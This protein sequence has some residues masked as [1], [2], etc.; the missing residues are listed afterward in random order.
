MPNTQVIALISQTK[1]VHYVKKF[2]PLVLYPQGSRVA[3]L[4]IKVI[5]FSNAGRPP[6]H[7]EISFFAGLVL[8]TFSQNYF[9]Y[10]LS[11]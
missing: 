1:Y 4:S 10:R 5:V 2:S 11:W 3:T 8:D 7:G 9:I 6:P